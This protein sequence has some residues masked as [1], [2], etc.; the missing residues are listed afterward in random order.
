MSAVHRVQPPGT[1]ATSRDGG[2]RRSYRGLTR[3]PGLLLVALLLIGLLLSGCLTE[4]LWRLQDPERVPDLETSTTVL[5]IDHVDASTGED[6][7]PIPD[8]LHVHFRPTGLGRAAPRLHRF[9]RSGAGTLQLER[10][11]PLAAGSIGPA[12]H[13]VPERWAL[14]V[15]DGEHLRS[16]HSVA[17]VTFLGRAPVNH[18]GRVVP[19]S[20]VPPELAD[21]K[22]PAFEGDPR[23]AYAQRMLQSFDEQ[24]WAALLAP[25]QTRAHDSCEAVAFLDAVGRPLR[26]AEVSELVLAAEWSTEARERLGGV[27]LLARV[28]RV[29]HDG[30]LWLRVPAPTLLAIEHSMLARAGEEIRFARQEHW[31]GSLVADA[32]GASPGGAA[33]AM[34]FALQPMGSAFAYSWSR[35]LETESDVLTGLQIALTPFTA[36]IDLIV[37]TNPPLKRLSVWLASMFWPDSALVRKWLQETGV[38]PARR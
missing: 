24:D 7:D 31:R 32:V 17:R 25:R 37:A 23:A 21:S 20:S 16:P 29:S 18:F 1:P 15:F 4:A 22:M 34:P 2:V 19:A 27:E 8:R 28:D 5:A 11:P 6:D 9:E 33:S 13:L 14:A 10:R 26:P 12:G 30:P 38:E 36:A 35:E 3:V